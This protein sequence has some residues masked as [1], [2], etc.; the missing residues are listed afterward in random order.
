MADAIRVKG[1]TGLNRALAQADRN[2]RLGIRAEYRTVAEPVRA[3]AETLSLANIRN[4]GV[5]WSRMR[6][7]ITQRAVYVVPKQRGARGR[8]NRRRRP[9]LA[10]LMY[11]QMQKALDINAP[12]IE[13]DFNE[14]LFG[15]ANKFN[16]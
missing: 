6:I 16:R 14:M 11:P 2:V 5:P 7:G 9:N 13:R 15:V 4:V 12:G 10:G 3:D 8:G 1:L